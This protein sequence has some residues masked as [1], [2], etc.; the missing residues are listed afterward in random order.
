MLQKTK[1]AAAALLCSLFAVQSIFAQSRPFPQQLRYPG[2]IIPT[3][4]QPN[5]MRDDVIG[6][7]NIYKSTYLRTEGNQSYI[8][9]TGT[10]NASSPNNITIS[11]A[12]GYGMIIFALMAGHDPEA[13]AIFDR[14]NTFRKNHKSK[15]NNNLL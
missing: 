4:R 6:F 7:Y 3:N 2:T 8:K 10:G 9:A 1:I 11:E 5:Q 12:H 13:K 14:M 15:I